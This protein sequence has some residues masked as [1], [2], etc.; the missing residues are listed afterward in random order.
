MGLYPSTGFGSAILTVG[1]SL[2]FADLDNDGWVE[3]VQPAAPDSTA[4]EMGFTE[5]P[6]LLWQ[7]LGPGQF[8]DVSAVTGFNS[9][10]HHFG[11]ATAD[12]DGDGFLD[13]VTAGPGTT[14]A[15]YMNQCGDGAWIEIEL[16]GPAENSQA[17]GAQ[18]E[19]DDG[20]R[21][22]LREVH[23]LRAT[24]Q[25]P[26]RLHFGLGSLGVVPRITIRWPDGEISEGN[27]IGT[28]RVITVSHSNSIETR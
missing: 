27:D 14:P 15:L 21:V 7:G 9:L 26:S 5:F 8:L 17:F 6:D 13:I 2:D 19:L 4:T 3:V 23:G 24:G 10:D 18:V 16:V 11:M 22:H 25:G 1:W 20:E 12:F 28:R